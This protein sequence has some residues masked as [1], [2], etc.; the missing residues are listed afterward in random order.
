[1]H[2]YGKTYSP[3]LTCANVY[4]IFLF[5]CILPWIVNGV[6][7]AVWESRPCRR[8]GLFFEAFPPAPWG[9]L[10]VS[11]I[12]RQAPTRKNRDPGNFSKV[13]RTFPPHDSRSLSLFLTFRTRRRDFAQV[14]CETAGGRR[15][16][17]EMIRTSSRCFQFALPHSSTWNGI[18]FAAYITFRIW[19][20]Y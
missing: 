17:E 3:T 9:A 8:C 6:T 18:T 11:G 14:L 15:G 10:V 20:P 2:V 19:L 5:F 7:A 4:L 12:M 16:G 13:V 1:M